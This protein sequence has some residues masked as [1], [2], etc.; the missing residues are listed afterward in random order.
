MEHEV[1]D[2]DFV[3]INRRPLED[4]FNLLTGQV[5][6]KFVRDPTHVLFRQVASF[7]HVEKGEDPRDT[8]MGVALVKVARSLIHELIEGHTELVVDG[9]IHAFNHIV[10]AAFALIKANS[11]EHLHH[12]AR[13][14]CRLRVRNEQLEGL[15][16]VV[17]L[18][19]TDGHGI[20][21]CLAS[22]LDHRVLSHSTLF[23]LDFHLL[24]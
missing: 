20:D 8:L 22:D 7:C 23:S 3:A 2:S 16:N 19:L 21:P 6:V 4:H 13:L 17:D 9:S 12:L 10:N 15:P 11:L 5:D 14:H 18:L 1:V 24:L